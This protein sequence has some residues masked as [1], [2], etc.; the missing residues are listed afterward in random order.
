M[1]NRVA[2]S[3]H[4]RGTSWPSFRCAVGAGDGQHHTMAWKIR[5]HTK[6]TSDTASDIALGKIFECITGLGCWTHTC[7]CSAWWWRYLSAGSCRHG[8]LHLY[9]P[10]ARL[11]WPIKE[12][13][14]G[15]PKYES[16]ECHWCQSFKEIFDERVKSSDSDLIHMPISSRRFQFKRARPATNQPI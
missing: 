3:I 16:D 10:S 7:G 4:H 13:C 5:A 8:D 12:L 15:W 9:C 11:G 2:P 1:T 14:L 6:D